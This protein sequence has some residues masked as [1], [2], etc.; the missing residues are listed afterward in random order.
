MDKL[1]K[2]SM[3]STVHKVFDPFGFV[4]PVMLCP[5][6]MLQKAWKL[7]TSWDEELTGEL[8]KELVQWFQELKY[9]SDIQIHWYIQMSHKTLS[10]CVIH[11]FVDGSK[12]A[13]G[14]VTFLRLE[15]DDQIEV[16]L[17]AEKSRVALLRGVTIPRMELLAVVIAASL[18]NSVVEAL[19]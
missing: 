9:L 10:N 2:R 14:A 19:S 5:K 11:T 13:Y 12:D 8:R 18:T 4:L 16:F 7:S 15:K 6:I 3:V 1:T 17:L